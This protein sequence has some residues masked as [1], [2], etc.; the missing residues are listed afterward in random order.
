MF[1]IYK[2]NINTK[3]KKIIQLKKMFDLIQYGLDLI[4]NK[5][6]EIVNNMALTGVKVYIKLKN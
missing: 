6:N 2:K 5:A 4:K 3:Y 1:S